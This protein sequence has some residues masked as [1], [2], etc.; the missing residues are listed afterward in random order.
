MSAYVNIN[1]GHPESS[2]FVIEAENLA[3]NY[4]FRQL[5]DHSCAVREK[6]LVSLFDGLKSIRLDSHMPGEE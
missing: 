2:P 3:M 6:I 4:F 5:I 1:A